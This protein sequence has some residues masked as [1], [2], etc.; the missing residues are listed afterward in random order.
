M[1]PLL[2]PL[3]RLMA[4]DARGPRPT[5]T[6]V[7]ESSDGVELSV[8]IPVFDE[9]PSITPLV[10]ALHRVLEGTGRAYEI[11]FVDDGSTDGSFDRIREAAKASPTVRAVR[12][13]RNFAKAAALT[14]GFGA[15]R[16]RYIITM[17]GDLQDDPEE[18]PRLISKLEEGFDLVSGWKIDRKD[19][20]SKTLPSKVFNW[21]TGRVTGM[22]LHDMN[23]GLK[24]YRAEVLREIRIYGELHR[25]IPVLAH[26]RGFA[27]TELPVR[28][29]PRRHG[30]SKY[31]ASRFLKGFVDLLTVMF[32]TRYTLRPLHLFGGMGVF[33]FAIG[34]A[35]NAYLSVVWFAGNM[36]ELIPDYS[37]IGNRPLLQLGVLLSIVGLQLVFTGLIGEMVADRGFE[38]ETTYSIR[39]TL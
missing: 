7:P 11:V 17:D 36:L 28:H 15:A 29:H 5:P 38:P 32:L 26:W 35:I 6:G 14:A 37:G 13:R 30:R 4:R 22:S 33:L 27:V 21:V 24:A 16:G 3:R 18:L 12:L 31:G 2:L 19:P 23:C 20:L 34:L 25:Y 1:A 10:E 39:E 9:E 8:V